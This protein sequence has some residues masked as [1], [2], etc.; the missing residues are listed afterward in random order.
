MSAPKY[1]MPIPWPLTGYPGAC[2]S[3]GAPEGVDCGV[4]TGCCIACCRLGFAF[5]GCSCE[6]PCLWEHCPKAV[7]P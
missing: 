7:D 4:E 1:L 3:C 2:V 5:H 6:I